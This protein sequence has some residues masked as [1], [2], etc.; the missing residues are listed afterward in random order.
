[1]ALGRSR[2]EEGSWVP[3]CRKGHK[4]TF[5]SLPPA[6]P[7]LE[8]LDGCVSTDSELIKSY[9][10]SAVDTEPSRLACSGMRVFSVLAGNGL[11]RRRG[12]PTLPSPTWLPSSCPHLPARAPSLPPH[13]ADGEPGSGSGA[14]AGA[15]GER[16]AGGGHSVVAVNF[17]TPAPQQLGAPLRQVWAGAEWRGDNNLSVIFQGRVASCKPQIPLTSLGESV[18][19]DSGR[20]GLQWGLYFLNDFFHSHFY[21]L[22]VRAC[23]CEC[24]R[25][26]MHVCAGAHSRVSLLSGVTDP[27]G[28]PTGHGPSLTLEKLPQRI[29][30]ALARSSVHLSHL[31]ISQ[32][33]PAITPFLLA[34]EGHSWV[35]RP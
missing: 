9:L 21:L 22:S 27:L 16:A 3:I 32:E 14:D 15:A 25:T 35:T 20:R 23:T 1:M 33:A 8:P 4:K 24:V 10:S 7:S 26:C 6:S 17:L 2:E 5:L 13:R 30:G 12:V 28:P 34:G 19:T 29:H 18:T 11:P 31:Q